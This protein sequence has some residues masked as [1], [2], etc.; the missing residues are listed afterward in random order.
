MQVSLQLNPWHKDK[1][2]VGSLVKTHNRSRL[3]RVLI[4][5]ICTST[6]RRSTEG[7]LC[8]SVE[9]PVSA[10][11]RGN[12]WRGPLSS[13]VL[14]GARPEHLVMDER[15]KP[16][17]GAWP[18]EREDWRR[19]REEVC[20]H[21]CSS[22]STPSEYLLEHKASGRVECCVSRDKALVRAC[23]SSIESLAVAPRVRQSRVPYSITSLCRRHWQSE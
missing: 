21:T 23:G 18:V 19:R 11:G 13:W 5:T 10:L 7:L 4:A 20:P 2:L 8:G 1:R 16:S 22:N 9:S 15:R 17:K 6:S 12:Y 3:T 14:G